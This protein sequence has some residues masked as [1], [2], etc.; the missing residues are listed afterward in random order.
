MVFCD[1][2][3]GGRGNQATYRRVIKYA[4]HTSGRNTSAATQTD[5]S[6]EGCHPF[7]KVAAQTK[8]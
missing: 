5:D 6:G 1:S 4:T 3:P 2:L 8:S 7:A